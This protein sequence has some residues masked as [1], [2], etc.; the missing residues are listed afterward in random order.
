VTAFL[1]LFALIAFDVN[2]DLSPNQAQAATY[3][4]RPNFTYTDT[5]PGLLSYQG[6]LADANGDPI[7]GNIEMTFRI[8]TT[9]LGGMPLYTETHP[10]VVVRD[11]DF[12]VLLGQTTP[13]PDGLFAEPNRYLGLQVGPQAEMVPRQRFASVAFAMNAYN[14][15]PPG[16]VM[17]YAGSTP[18]EGWLICDGSTLSRTQYAELFA[19]IGTAHGE[20]NGATT[21]NLPDYRGYFLRG[22][23][24]G[25]GR[26]PDVISRT[27]VI[28][29]GNTGDAVG[30][31]QEDQMQSHKHDDSG[32]THGYYTNID[33]EGH[34]DGPYTSAENDNTYQTTETGYANLTDPVTSTAGLVRHGMETRPRN[35]YVIWIIKY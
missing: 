26:D 16:S 14:G 6:T 20:G 5:V 30:S 15:S 24:M 34:G 1:F 7:D 22:V 3:T 4:L 21:F 9:T 27:A 23:D 35:A 29:G 18:P 13:F 19:A 2:I 11:G 31:V 28:T 33:Q 25:A 17:A 32:H 8:Y 10:A 12:A